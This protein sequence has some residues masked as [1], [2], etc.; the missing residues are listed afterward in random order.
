MRNRL[1][2]V[3]LTSVVVVGAQFVPGISQTVILPVNY[4][5]VAGSVVFRTAPGSKLDLASLSGPA[6][7]EI[8]GWDD[9]FASDFA[10]MVAAKKALATAGPAPS[11]PERT[12][13]LSTGHPLFLP[14]PSAELSPRIGPMTLFA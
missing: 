10:A 3:L 9:P 11:S 2:V 4:A 7:F 8:D 6:S 1:A 12:N 14:D 13:P 5:L